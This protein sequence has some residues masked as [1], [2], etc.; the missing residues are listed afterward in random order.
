MNPDDLDPPKPKSVEPADL[1]ILS[2][3]ALE[4]YIEE[5]HAEIRRAE[6]MIEKKRAARDAAASVFK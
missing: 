5:R 2:I 1:E 6:E 3:D 4:E